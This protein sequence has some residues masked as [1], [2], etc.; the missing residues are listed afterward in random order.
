MQHAHGTAAPVAELLCQALYQ[1]MGVKHTAIE[2]H[3]IGQS[4]RCVLR[5]KLRQMAA[6]GSVCRV[7]QT[8]AAQRALAFG[9]V[10]G[11][12]SRR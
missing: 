10:I 1:R 2:Q 8:K 9:G 4:A 6:D 7:R 3:G 11:H 5:Q 12:G